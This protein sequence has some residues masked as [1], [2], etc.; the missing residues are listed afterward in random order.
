MFS[1]ILT[2]LEN[3]S[4]QD[5]RLFFITRKKNQN[6]EYIVYQT[7]IGE[8]VA[9][10]LIKTIQKFLEKKNSDEIQYEEYDPNRIIKGNIIQCINSND[11]DSFL[12]IVK[13]IENPN[14]EQFNLNR[15][16]KIW[17]YVILI[18][19]PRVIF[20]TKYRPSK[21]LQ[22]NRTIS[23]LYRKGRYTKLDENLITLENKVDC[24]YYKDYIYILQPN[25]FEKI[26]DYMEILIGNIENNLGIIE[27]IDVLK[28]LQDFWETCKRDHKKVKKLNNIL[29]KDYVLKLDIEKIRKIDKDYNLNLIYENNSIVINNQ[30]I[31]K[32]LHIFDD[33]LLKSPYSKE[34][35]IAHTKESV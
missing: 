20:F 11:V 22:S 19:K 15:N 3:I 18:D 17:A 23:L 9:D 29:S 12:N 14:I 7:I 34:K 13:Q 32:I 31:W 16:Q 10:S 21:I 27:N 8:D 26:F 35:Y 24:Y 30:T 5:I 33:D 6:I 28:D 2:I 4:K 25:N 1:E